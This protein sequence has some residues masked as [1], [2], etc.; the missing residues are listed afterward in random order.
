MNARDV[1]IHI[2]NGGP[3]RKNAGQYSVRCP[4]HD[5]NAPSL[6]IGDGKDGTVLHCFAGCEVVDILTDAGL[7]WADL[8]DQHESGSLVQTTV[9]PYHD[10][11]GNVLFEV[12]RKP[13]KKFL[14]RTIDPSAPEGH[15]WDMKGT[16]RV[17]Y[18]LPEVVEAAR[19]GKEVWVAEGEKDA[20]VLRGHGLVGTTNPGGAGK[21]M[22][23]FSRFFGAGVYVTVWADADE[24]GRKHARSVRAS[25]MEEG[26]EV[27]IVES[28]VGKDADEHFRF[29]LG[30]EDVV[31]TQPYR[32]QAEPELFM[33]LDD[34]LDQDLP[35]PEW[36]VY[37][38]MRQ[39]EVLIL[40][41][42]EGYGKSSL[43]KQ[44]SVCS[45]LG[46]HPF[47]TGRTN[48]GKP[49][50]VVHIDCENKDY[51]CMVDFN[52]LRTAA[53]RDGVW[54]DDPDLF[55]HNREDLNL[56]DSE[57]VQW[58][59]ERV[60][61]HN[62]DLLV[63][64]PLTNLIGSDIGRGE[65]PIRAVRSAIRKVHKV[66]K[67]AVVIEHH[68]PHAAP[69]ETRQV[70]PI[71]STLLMRWPSFGFGLMPMEP[72]KLHEP[73]EF[74]PWRGSRRRG[75]GWPTYIQQAGTETEGWF[76]EECEGP[77]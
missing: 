37:P 27:R 41:G 34:F 64:G 67:C 17:L 42:F 48:L 14:Q 53:Q 22:D 35:V 8:H 30:I 68:T 39:Q 28:P 70:R 54:L 66:A 44:M 21:W 20:D 46:L 51:D 76:W 9:Y 16:R 57:H 24:P 2:A 40:T 29:G 59:V 56:E 60:H 36:A 4:H 74:L 75:R 69:G 12:V 33:R 25:L 45:A 38:L 63:I 10:E 15:R 26:T 18:R 3:V 47:T 11:A 50:R 55:V 72:G 7:T 1:A 65:D 58:L 73:F 13:D 49:Q 19:A 43:L 71:G 61:A 5:D 32:D 31:V 52:R 77:E 23:T 6:S 62:P